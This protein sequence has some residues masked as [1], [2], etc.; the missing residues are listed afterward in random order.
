MLQQIIGLMKL[1]DPQATDLWDTHANILLPLV[2]QSDAIGRAI[3][4]FDYEKALQL[5]G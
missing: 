2:K 1:D 4:E 3:D 5:L